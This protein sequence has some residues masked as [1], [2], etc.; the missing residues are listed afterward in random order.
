MIAQ[1]KLVML[2]DKNGPA[3]KHNLKGSDL[4][5]LLVKPSLAIDLPVEER[6]TDEEILSRTS[7]IPL[8]N[9]NN[10]KT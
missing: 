6:M 9:T 8:G 1:K 10:Q 7:P 4:L 5:S 3:G 2:A